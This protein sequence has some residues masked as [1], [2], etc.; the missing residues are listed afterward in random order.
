MTKYRKLPVE[1]IL[2]EY[3]AGASIN[4]IARDHDSYVNKV[5]RLLKKHIEIRGHSEAQA[6]LLQQGKIDHPT[7]GRERTQQEKLDISASQHKSW[8]EYSDEKR[9]NIADTSRE[10]WY[11]QSEDKRD[12]I[13]A[14]AAAG[15]RLAA[16]EGSRVEKFLLKELKKLYQVRFHTKVLSTNLE[17][18][19]FLPE[20]NAA[21]EV[22][23]P[24]HYLPIWSDE[25]LAKQQKYDHEKYSIL[26]TKGLRIIKVKYLVSKF[27]LFVQEQLKKEI[28]ELLPRIKDSDKYIYEVNIV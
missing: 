13:L 10:L 23:G 3:K 11:N 14:A 5:K 21:I 22:N 19:L 20:L 26:L 8:S 15:S 16:K 24:S 28:L 17:V 6:L 9:K 2:K 12:E 4:Q 27:T 7:E 25:A 18:D 1:Q